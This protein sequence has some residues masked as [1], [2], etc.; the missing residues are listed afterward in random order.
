MSP[1]NIHVDTAGVRSRKPGQN[2]HGLNPFTKGGLKT[3]LG[4]EVH[5]SDIGPKAP[6]SFTI[7]LWYHYTFPQ[8]SPLLFMRQVRWND[9]RGQDSILQHWPK[10]CALVMR[11]RE[12]DRETETE[13]GRK[14]KDR[15]TDGETDREVRRDTKKTETEREKDRLE[16]QKSILPS[17][18]LE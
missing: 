5:V 1:A 7:T 8:V 3:S 14:E 11:E 10:K 17:N 13:R 16:R 4:P 6:G 2:K 9:Y 15:K 12:R 18:P